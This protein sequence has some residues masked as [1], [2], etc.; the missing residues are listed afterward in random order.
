MLVVA[1]KEVR[2]GAAAIVHALEHRAVHRIAHVD[3]P[4]GRHGDGSASPIGAWLS[5]VQRQSG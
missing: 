1:L 4:V 5:P 2:A 3:R